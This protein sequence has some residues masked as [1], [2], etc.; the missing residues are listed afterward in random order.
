MAREEPLPRRDF[1]GLE[2]DPYCLEAVRESLEKWARER[3]Q[4]VQA[5]Q[6]MP[7]A[8][9]QVTYEPHVTN[10]EESE[11]GAPAQGQSI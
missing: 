11:E 8:F 1:P 9:E 5:L 6:S 2:K 4:S 7:N 3:V 10:T